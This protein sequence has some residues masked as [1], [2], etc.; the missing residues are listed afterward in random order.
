MLDITDE[1][2]P[3]GNTHLVVDDVDV[4]GLVVAG[5]MAEML[6]AEGLCTR[7]PGALPRSM[8]VNLCADEP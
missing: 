2:L 7:A 3:A 6:G 8:G 4:M 5:W 1:I